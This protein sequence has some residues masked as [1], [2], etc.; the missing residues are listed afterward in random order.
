MGERRDP[1]EVIDFY[2]HKILANQSIAAI[3][4]IMRNNNIEQRDVDIF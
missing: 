3:K 4:R 1:F 2:N